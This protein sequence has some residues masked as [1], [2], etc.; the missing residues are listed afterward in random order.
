MSFFSLA[1]FRPTSPAYF[2][3]SGFP[4]DLKL[5]YI[6]SCSAHALSW[7]WRAAAWNAIA[8]PIALAWN[9]SGWFIHTS[10]TSLPYFCSRPLTV[11][12]D[13]LQNGHSKS[14]NSTMVTLA[15]AGP[16]RTL[17][18]NGNTF[19]AP[20]AAGAA[21]LGDGEPPDGFCWSS[22]AARISPRPLPCL[23]R[24][25]ALRPSAGLR[26][27]FGS[28]LMQPAILPM[29]QPHS[30]S[31]SLS[32]CSTVTFCGAVS[33]ARLNVVTPVRSA[34]FVHPSGNSA[35]DL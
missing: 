2:S 21:A 28:F 22:M 17:C 12:S 8:A 9:G 18:A 3:I 6:L 15:L 25:I 27:Q 34:S 10:A 23:T 4:S 19:F 11:G 1:T 14:L 13:R 16:R 31:R 30:Q 33:P 35:S 26:G 7:F 29:P 24:S 32:A 5:S 20:P